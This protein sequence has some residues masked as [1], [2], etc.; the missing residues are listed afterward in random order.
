MLSTEAKDLYSEIESAE[1]LRDA[2]IASMG[3]QVGK[4]HGPYYQERNLQEHYAAENHYYEYIS[5]VVPRLVFDNPRVR[6]TTRRP[7]TQDV[8]AKAIRHG[9]NRW[10][11]DT[12]FRKILTELATDMLFSYGV[13]LITE[14]ENKGLRPKKDVIDEATPMWPTCTRIPQER[15]IIDPVATSWEDARFMGHKW[16]RDKED[17][18]QQ[19]KDNPDEGWDLEAVKG[20]STTTDAGHLGRKKNDDT[21]DREEVVCYEIWIPEIDTKDSLGGSAGFH[22]SIYTLAV[23]SEGSNDEKKA[24]FIRE[25][26]P[27]YGPR[28]GPYVMFGVYGVPSSIYPLSPLIAIEGQIEE[29][30]RH[31]ESASRSAEQYKR[32]IFVDDTDPK[33]VQRVKD[34]THHFVIPVNGLEKQRVVQAEIGGMTPAQLQYLQ[35]ARD[36]LDRNSGISDAQR[37]NIEG[38]GTA[39]EVTVA[40][41]ASTIRLAF[42]KQQF[43]DAVEKVLQTVAWFFYHDDRVVLPLGPEAERDLGVPEPWL[44]GGEHDPESGATFDDLELEIEPYSMERSTEGTQQQ[45]MMQLVNVILETAP[46]VPQLPYVNW[47][48]LYHRL[49]DTFNQ[50]DLGSLIDVNIAMQMAQAEGV[51]HDESKKPQ[52][53]LQKDVGKAGK[54]RPKVT[55]ASK[56]NLIERTNPQSDLMAGQQTGIEAMRGFAQ[57]Q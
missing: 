42:M 2:H 52:P 44:V 22:G 50:D 54:A 46:L 47:D 56:E 23:I 57:Q 34:G 35:V 21:P 29:L 1:R 11:R 12:K 17:L 53:R 41:E 38:R 51:E 27:Y 6:V 37:G 14:E 32:L 31:A 18:I 48:E 3:D 30:N 25:P 55:E 10:I 40:A 26:R 24:A 43:S 5:L 7:G 13:G 33:F 9:L 15:F 19:A 20:L 4:Y 16:I 39:T 36:R 49:G 45:K 8:V 28:W